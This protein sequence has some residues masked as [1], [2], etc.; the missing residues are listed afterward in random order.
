MRYLTFIYR[1]KFGWKINTFRAQ[2]LLYVAP[3]RT[4]RISTFCPQSVNQ[5][6]V[7]ISEQRLVL[8]YTAF[9]DFFCE[10]MCFLCG[11]NSVFK[12]NSGQFSSLNGHTMT[13]TVSRRPVT[14]ETWVLWQESPYEICGGESGTGTGFTPSTSAF[15]CHCNF[16]NAPYS[17]TCTRGFYQKDKRE[18]PGKLPQNKVVSY[19]GGHLM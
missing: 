6:C 8:S 10:K 5:C 16:S 7:W 18:K 4:L 9:S 15:P 1:C 13:Y 2:W 3:G 12:C 11:M 17:F 19:I 14:A